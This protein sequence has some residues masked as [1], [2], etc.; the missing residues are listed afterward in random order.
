MIKKLKESRGFTLI[1]VVIVLAIA[2]LIILVVLQAVAAAQLANRDT[3]RKNEGARAASLLEQIASN[4]DGDYPTAASVDADISGYDSSLG[5]K[6]TITGTTSSAAP[7]CGGNVAND[8]YR[9]E[10]TVA[11]NRKSYKINV[12]T[13]K[14]PAAGVAITK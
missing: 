10:Y 1:E 9:M 2:A 6:Y 11:T 12:C 8:V 7:N 4:N 14:G 3:T 5:G 13:E